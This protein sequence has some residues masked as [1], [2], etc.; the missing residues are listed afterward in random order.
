MQPHSPVVTAIGEIEA[1][2]SDRAFYT[3]TE[4]IAERGV[5]TAHIIAGIAGVDK[6]G[7]ADIA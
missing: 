3:G 7:N 2:R 4:A 1:E 5:Q 6:G